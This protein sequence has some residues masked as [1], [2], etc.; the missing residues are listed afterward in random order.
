VITGIKFKK[1]SLNPVKSYNK[2]LNKPLKM[3]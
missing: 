1:I 3:L 2:Y